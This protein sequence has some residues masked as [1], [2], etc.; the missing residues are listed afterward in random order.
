MGNQKPKKKNAT[1]S[2]LDRFFEKKEML[3]TS[4]KTPDGSRTHVSQD[5]LNPFKNTG[6]ALANSLA[7]SIL[8]S[9]KE[10]ESLQMTKPGASASDMTS[11]SEPSKTIA[12]PPASITEPRAAGSRAALPLGRL[13]K[14]GQSHEV[15][16]WQNTKIISSDDRNPQDH[17]SLATLLND[18]LVDQARRHG[19]D[20][21]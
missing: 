6:M 14:V 18:I 20:L 2:E 7:D 4:S 16:I 5:T 19:V 3:Y 17:E 12:S 21:S 8:S 15:D 1:V 9:S 11:A 13:P 10:N